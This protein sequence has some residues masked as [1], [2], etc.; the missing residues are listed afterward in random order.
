[1]RQ[2]IVVIALFVCFLMIVMPLSDGI[3]KH[4]V[5]F[6]KYMPDGHIDT[7]TT[8]ITLNYNETVSEGISRVCRQLLLSDTE[9]QRYADQGF[10]LYM[11]VSSGSGFHFTF[12]SSFFRSSHFNI[13]YSLL[14]SI[15][16]CNYDNYFS[17]TDIYPIS[18]P[19]NATS[20]AGSHKLVCIGF[21]G[22][23]GWTGYFSRGS[24]GFAGFSP[25]VWF[26][27]E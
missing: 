13:I 8:E 12:P 9:L 24:T 16:F 22:I 25:F 11:I 1:M 26:N 21:V 2:K 18:D 14:P 20:L 15:I 27:T 10:D 17:V 23:I 7:F 3:S 5:T 19:D 4:H 6:T